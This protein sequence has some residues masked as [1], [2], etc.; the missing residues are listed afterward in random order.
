MSAAFVEV[1]SEMFFGIIS[2]ITTCRYTMTESAM[3]NEMG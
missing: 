2:P 1:A 3:A